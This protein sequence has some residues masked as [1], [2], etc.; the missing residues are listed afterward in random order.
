MTSFN[1]YD[2]AGRITSRTDFDG[3]TTTYAYAL[4]GR[5]ITETYSDGTTRI[6][7]R[8]KDGKTQSITGTA[9]IAQYYTY[10]VNEDGSQWTTD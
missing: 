2:L 9:Q 5:Q 8:H 3:R 7:L 4:A 10:G 6:T 1:T